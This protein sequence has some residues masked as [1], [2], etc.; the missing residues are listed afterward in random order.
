MVWD[1]L[2]LFAFAMTSRDLTALAQTAEDVTRIHQLLG[3]VNPRIPPSRNLSEPTAVS[4]AVNLLA[5]NELDTATQTLT[6]VA[7][8]SITWT[9]QYLTWDPADYGGAKHFYPDPAEVWRP[10]IVVQNTKTQLYPLGKFLQITAMADGTNIW[11]PGDVISTTCRVDVTYF[12]FD[13]HTCQVSLVVW[14]E[15]GTALLAPMLD[16]IDLT[17]FT[18]SSEWELLDTSVRDILVPYSAEGKGDVK[19][20]LELTLKRRASTLVVTVLLP[21]ALLAAI[22]LVVFLI[23][24]ESGERI[25]F[26]V[27]VLLSYGV[28]LT[29]VTDVMPTAS[30]SVSILV[31]YLYSLFMVSALFLLLSVLTVRLHHFDCSVSPSVAGYVVCLERIVHPGK[32]FQNRVSSLNN[33]D[34]IL[35]DKPRILYRG[36]LEKLN[37]PRKGEKQREP[38]EITNSI[39]KKIQ[40][41][42]GDEICPPKGMTW[43]RVVRTVDAF[44]FRMFSVVLFVATIIVALLILILR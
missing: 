33:T 11:Y 24:C 2:V 36:S 30:D 7:W 10:S 12:P 17:S 13:E 8:F 44:L 27:T 34:D 38:R 19:L 40:P 9:N 6:L 1:V 43:K 42:S 28:F 4:V 31:L 39:P 37:N 29:F 22:N 16:K 14:S 20:L 41:D 23:P 21:V 18:E 25:S 35:D 32:R 26:A 3:D 15:P 5:I